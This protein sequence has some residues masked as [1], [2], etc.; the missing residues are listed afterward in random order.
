MY[1]G[2]VKRFPRACRKTAG[3]RTKR[4]RCAQGGHEVD[5]TAAGRRVPLERLTIIL[6]RILCTIIKS[7]DRQ[8]NGFFALSGPCVLVIGAPGVFGERKTRLASFL[9]SNPKATRVMDG[10][11]DNPPRIILLRLHR[12]RLHRIHGRTIS[13][14]N[15][16]RPHC[17][18]STRIRTISETN[19]SGHIG[20]FPNPVGL[21]IIIGFT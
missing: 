17:S 9:G 14:R 11:A 21:S 20:T 8:W 2:R 10:V 1:N 18:S 16:V 7:N 6:I 15:L 13:N 4:V 12:V 5:Y 3:F 19:R